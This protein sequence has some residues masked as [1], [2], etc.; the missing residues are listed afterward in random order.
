MA[1]PR[2]VLLQPSIGEPIKWYENGQRTKELL[3][4]FPDFTFSHLEW[5]CYAWPGGYEIFYFVKDGGVLCHNCANEEL[6]R[7][8]DPD[9]EQF[10]IVEADV[11]W[12]GPSMYCDH[13][14]RE[15]E[16]IYEEYQGVED[17]ET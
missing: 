5:E 3:D 16:P 8:I 9:D 17:N 11:N 1:E 4:Q 13:C 15:I 7:T 10:Y 6:I 12:E 2:H 14:N